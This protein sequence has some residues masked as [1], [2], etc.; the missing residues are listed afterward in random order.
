[1][2]SEVSSSCPDHDSVEIPWL[3]L[4]CGSDCT[5]FAEISSSQQG[6]MTVRMEMN[7][8][9]RREEAFLC[10]HVRKDEL[11]VKEVVIDGRKMWCLDTVE[12]S[13]VQDG[14]CA[15]V[16]KLTHAGSGEDQ[17]LSC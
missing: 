8:K 16:A 1:M 3:S 4:S 14:R 10:G 9:R 11:L 12:V 15:S 5:S 7:F 17:V 6:V 2:K 13:Q